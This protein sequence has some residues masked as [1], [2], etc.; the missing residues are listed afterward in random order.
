VFDCVGH[1]LGDGEPK[2]LGRRMIAADVLGTSPANS[3]ATEA[4]AGSART[5]ISHAN[6]FARIFRWNAQSLRRFGT[7]MAGASRMAAGLDT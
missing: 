5:Q 2:T 3:R 6:T 1:R 7:R 4:L